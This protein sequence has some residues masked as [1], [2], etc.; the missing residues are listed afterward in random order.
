MKKIIKIIAG[1]LVVL[2]AALVILPYMFRDRIADQIKKQINKQIDAEFDFE[3]ADLSLFRSFP[4]VALTLSEPEVINK[5]PFKGDTLFR[6]GR[7]SMSLPLRTLWDNSG[8]IS[9]NEFL[10]EQPRMKIVIDSAGKA[11]YDIYKA[12]GN[13]APAEPGG[14]SAG[15]DLRSYRIE[16]GKISYE[17]YGTGI[18]LLLDSLEHSG[19]GDLSQVVS[20]LNTQTR[21]KV[22]FTYDSVNYLDHH[23]VDLEALLEIDLEQNKY[24][25]LENKALVNRLP[26]IFDGYVQLMDE[27]QMVDLSFSTPAS[28]FSNFLALIPEAY[29]GNI[30][31]VTT[32]GDFKV[33]GRING[34]STD[35]R[36]PAFSIGMVAENASFNYPDLPKSVDDIEFTG[37]LANETGDTDDTYMHID[38][39]RFRIDQDRFAAHALIDRLT[40][41]MLVDLK[42][43]GRINLGSL[44]KAYPLPMEEELNGI[45]TVDMDAN[46]DQRSIEQEN[47][48]NVR[49]AGSMNARDVRYATEMLPGIV[50]IETANLALNNNKVRLSNTMVKTG[51]SDMKL[52]GNL[53]KV[54]EAVMN[55]GVMKGDFELDSQKLVV[56]DF[57]TAVDS[58]N[59]DASGETEDAFKLPA[60]LDLRFRGQAAT[61]VYDNIELKNARVALSLADQELKFDDISAN[62]LGGR[63]SLKGTLNT[64]EN[65]PQFDMNFGLN[66]LDIASS[67]EKVDLLKRLVP[68]AEALQGVLNSQLRLNGNLGTDLTPVLNSLNG[69]ADARITTREVESTSMPLVNQLSNNLSF[70]D[71]KKLEGRTI[72]TYLEFSDGKVEVR[73]F[74]FTFNDIQV[75]VSGGHNFDMSMNYKLRFEVP[76]RYLGGEVQSLL[77]KVGGADMTVPVTASVTG[78]YT[79][80]SVSTDMD[81]AVSTLTTRLVQKQRDELTKKG[82]DAVGGA[83]DKLLGSTATDSVSKP[84]D[85]SPASREV[86][87]E[88]A[89]QLLKGI[90]GKKKKDT[91]NRK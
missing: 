65:E 11:N 89:G 41:N 61:V 8:E 72:E 88:K 16:N 33:N 81:E 79:N 22:S 86:I 14:S 6:A 51:Q 74:S 43:K 62:A 7:L 91:V 87:E 71:L 45:I 67:F 21:G 4:D 63:L 73:P 36:I 38:T 12:G 69:N 49:V 44:S 48:K 77:Q 18:Y 66:E 82:T 52:S 55:G 13:E 5:E 90:F 85:S 2:L 59:T 42:A 40:G 1:I 70:F 31:G 15:I 53:D 54:L 19:Q 39:L 64:R 29:S 25:F 10:M 26:L 83:L 56:S 50:M 9:V 30:Q 32:S 37:S 3:S 57:K 68:L 75:N 20:R 84:K 35:E 46:F 76:A 24:S 47:Y 28:D 23:S 58:S 78:S 60:N 27:G 17:D 80:P 34:M